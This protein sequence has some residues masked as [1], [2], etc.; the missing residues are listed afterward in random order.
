MRRFVVVKQATDVVNPR[1]WLEETLS[2]DLRRSAKMEHYHVGGKNRFR[3]DNLLFLL[4]F[5]IYS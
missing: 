5:K 3:V 1:M 2:I 4:I